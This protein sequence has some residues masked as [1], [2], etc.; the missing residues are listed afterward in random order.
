MTP[1]LTGQ[2]FGHRF[3]DAV[4]RFA[5]EHFGPD[6]VRV[7]VASFN[8]RALSLYRKFG[9]REQ[10]EFEEPVSGVSYTILVSDR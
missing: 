5:D 7:T 1:E 8:D 4:L 9:F 6:R 10:D 2:G 3:F